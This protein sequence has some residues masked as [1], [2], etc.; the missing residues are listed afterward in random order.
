VDAIGGIDVMTQS[1]VGR[2][3][4]AAALGLGLALLGVGAARAESAWVRS[5]VRLN[6]RTGPGSEYR[7]VAGLKTGD[8]VTVLRR[9][10][11]WTRVR[12]AAGKEGWIPGGYLSTQPPPRIRLGQ[13]EAETETLRKQVASLEEEGA[14]LTD[15]N[16]GYQR[17]ETG[18]REEL[19]RLAAENRELKAGARW[20]EWITGATILSVGMVVGAILA[21]L[22]V[23][24]QSRRIRL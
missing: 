9:S 14:R 11:Q 13:L 17:R 18:Q 12:T 4:A 5:E 21:R 15:S 16:E 10:D 1:R 22:G 23:R 6:V 2:W 24:R 7:I 8:A 19:E 3:W 20:P